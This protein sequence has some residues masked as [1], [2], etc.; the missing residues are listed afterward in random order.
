MRII[1]EII[2]ICPKAKDKTWH[3]EV[4]A[5]LVQGYLYRLKRTVIRSHGLEVQIVMN[6]RPKW[7]SAPGDARKEHQKA[8]RDYQKG[9]Y[10]KNGKPPTNNE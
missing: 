3:K 5:D 10:Y 4:F 7:L 8:I 6:E 1:A 9:I 2:F